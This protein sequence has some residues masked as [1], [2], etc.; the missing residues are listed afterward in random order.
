MAHRDLYS[1]SSR[2]LR[3]QFLVYGMGLLF[4][5]SRRSALSSADSASI[6]MIPSKRNFQRERERERKTLRYIAPLARTK[7]TA[8][9]HTPY[10]H[11]APGSPLSRTTTI[12]TYI[13][14]RLL[15]LQCRGFL[16]RCAAVQ[17]QREIPR[18]RTIYITR[19]WGGGGGQATRA[20]LGASHLPIKTH[21]W[22]ESHGRFT[23]RVILYP[24]LA[25]YTILYTLYIYRAMSHLRFPIRLPQVTSASARI[26]VLVARPLRAIICARR[27]GV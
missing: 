25:L 23:A 9:T 26:V 8:D 24:S 13:Y 7:S 12:P 4:L 27:E 6:E 2:V 22:R 11:S 19:R 20:L 10:C 14:I 18:S 16:I 15:L 3:I 1:L 5:Q 21:P 17:H